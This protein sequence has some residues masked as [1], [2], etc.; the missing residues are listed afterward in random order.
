MNL[1]GEM[2]A[3]IGGVKEIET[4]LKKVD[5]ESILSQQAGEL[6]DR[7]IN[8]SQELEYSILKTRLLP[9]SL[10]FSQFKRIVRDLS[11]KTG[12]LIEITFENEDTEVDKKII[13]ALNEPLMHLVRNACDHGIESPEQR[14]KKGKPETGRITLSAFREGNSIKISCSDDGN[15]IDMGQIKSAALKKGIKSES[16]LNEMTHDDLMDLLFLPGFSTMEKVTDLSGR[17]VGLDVVKDSLKKL[18]GNAEIESEPD[19]GSVFILTLP[20]TL[21]TTNVILAKVEDLLVSLPT[22]EVVDT[23]K[24]SPDQIRS[25]EGTRSFVYGDEIL[26]LVSTRRVMNIPEITA[27]EKS[28]V[29]VVRYNNRKAGL[30]IDKIAGSAEVVI[31]NIETNYTSV[32]GFSGV[33]ILVD[34]TLSPVIDPVGFMNLINREEGIPASIR[35]E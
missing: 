25:I 2:A 21:T 5:S 19:M 10:V 8:L 12:K 20:L 26:P 14:Q 32:E 27:Q 28:L 35:K 15:G 3:A 30:V 22:S 23:L 7:L 29:L 9:V 24:L 11:R 1:I 4:A 6:S 31:K 33:T 34:G 18:N 17:G 16:E 13:D